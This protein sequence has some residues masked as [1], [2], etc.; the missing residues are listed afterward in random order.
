MKKE[1][2]IWLTRINR[3]LK[4]EL[5]SLIILLMVH[6]IVSSP[7][8][9]QEN[10]E[11]SDSDIVLIKKISLLRNELSEARTVQL[12]DLTIENQA[13]AAW[14]IEE[15]LNRA[16]QQILGTLKLA[17][18][19]ELN[20]ELYEKSENIVAQAV[21][22]LEILKGGVDPFDGKFAEPGGYVTDHAF[23][24][25]GNKYH[26][27]Y[28]RGIAATDWPA[29]NLYNFGHAVSCDLKNW[30]IEKPV[31][32]CPESGVDQ[33]QVWAPFILKRK[34]IYYMF[35][36]GVNT[37]VCQSICLATSKDLYNW[38]RYGSNPV[39]IPG[40]W[41][42]G[43]YDQNKWSDCRDPMVL[44]D[45]RNFYC[46]YTARRM[47]KENRQKE[48]CIGISSS[49]DLINWKDEG[50][51]PLRYSMKTPPESPFVV[52]HK[53]TFYLIYTNYKYGIVYLT[54]KDPVKGW[55]EM[56]EDKMSIMAGVS[57]TELLKVGNQWQMSLISHVNNGLRFLEFRKFIWNKDG[58]LTVKQLD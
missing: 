21:G 16:E 29:Y 57:A 17:H 49:H 10:K 45:G 51:I 55:Q 14:I 19:K 18:K 37:N 34:G 26:V 1:N 39:V 53:Q 35:Y 20:W 41:E 15:M 12:E 3:M 31:L 5:S 23:V 50:F 9:A 7:V 38:E 56:P 4:T 2:E 58:S 47:N 44:K 27:F 28:I 30:K 8:Q 25:K 24:K 11:L 46:Y 13:K 40:A 43:V 54:S 6:G 52:K 22:Y 42:E 32:Q 48:H 36:T 33:F